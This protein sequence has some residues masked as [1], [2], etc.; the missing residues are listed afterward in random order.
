MTQQ[1]EDTNDN[2]NNSYYRNINIG[3]KNNEINKTMIMVMTIRDCGN[4]VMNKLDRHDYG[5]TS[6]VQGTVLTY[7]GQETYMRRCISNHT[8]A[9][10]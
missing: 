5:D 4:N 9:C 8:M 2:N 6:T 1:A 3:N 7:T 10:C